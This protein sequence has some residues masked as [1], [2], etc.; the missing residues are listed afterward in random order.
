M[1]ELGVF[2]SRVGKMV[3]LNRMVIKLPFECN[4]SCSNNVATTPNPIQPPLKPLSQRVSI[5]RSAHIK[6]HCPDMVRRT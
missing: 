5:V 1:E 3:H 2:L 4:Y 6:E